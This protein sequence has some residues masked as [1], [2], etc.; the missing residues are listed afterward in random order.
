MNIVDKI[1]NE[2]LKADV[3][4]FAVGDTVNSRTVFHRY[5]RQPLER[6]K[7]LEHRD[8]ACERCR[9]V[10]YVCKRRDGSLWRRCHLQSRLFSGRGQRHDADVCG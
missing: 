7:Q 10:H 2:Q 4:D 1:R 6:R 8:A 9:D 3:A 5:N